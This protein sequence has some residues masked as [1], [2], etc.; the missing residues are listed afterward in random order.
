MERLIPVQGV[1]C[2]ISSLQHSLGCALLEPREFSA[3]PYTAATHLTGETPFHL[4]SRPISLV[5]HLHKNPNATKAKYNR[6]NQAQCD[7]HILDTE[8][9]FVQCKHVAYG[10]SHL[11]RIALLIV[12]HVAV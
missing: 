6:L 5:I 4:S 3:P 8:M 11:K 12:C 7:V 1:L 2:V 10:N 9:L